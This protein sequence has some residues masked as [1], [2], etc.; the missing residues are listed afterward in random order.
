LLLLR[1]KRPVPD[2]FFT[3]FGKLDEYRAKLYHDLK[4]IKMTDK[5]P[6]QYRTQ[7]AITKAL[8]YQ[9]NEDRYDKPDSVVFI[10]KF[11]VEYEKKKGWVYFYKYKEERDDNFWQLASIGVQPEK[12]D[13]IDIENDDFTDISGHKITNDK[14]LQDQ[15]QKMLNELLNSQRL[16]AAGFYDSRGYNFYRNY[17]S[18][19]VKRERFND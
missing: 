7:E 8:F 17:L 10:Q 2:S 16:S 9:Q 3:K 1:N 5:I 13:S 4:K 12:A 15:M 19:F 11:P 18:D 6:P 14:S